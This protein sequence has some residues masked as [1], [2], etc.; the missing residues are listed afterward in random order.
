MRT[1]QDKYFSYDSASSTDLFGLIVLIIVIRPSPQRWSGRSTTHDVLI[2][3]SPICEPSFSDTWGPG[4]AHSR[5]RPYVI[6]PVSSLLTHTVY[7]V[8]FLSYLAGSKS[9][10]GLPPARPAIR[11]SHLDTT[12]NIALQAI[13]STSGNNMSITSDRVIFNYSSV[14]MPTTT[15]F[16]NRAMCGQVQRIGE[17]ITSTTMIIGFL[18]DKWR[19]KKRAHET[20]NQPNLALAFDLQHEY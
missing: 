17:P 8:P 11:P 13:A 1:T 3:W 2:L 15:E 16:M 10:S 9:L 18:L 4:W 6:F 20:R 14:P 5:A 19:R 7:L 12:T